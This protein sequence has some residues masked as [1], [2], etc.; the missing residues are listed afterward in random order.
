MAIKL[1]KKLFLA[2]S[3]YYGHNYINCIDDSSFYDRLYFHKNDIQ[4]ENSYKQNNNNTGSNVVNSD[5]NLINNNG[6]NVNLYNN[7]GSNVVNSDNNLINNSGYNVNLYNNAGSNIV[8]SVNNLI[9]NNEIKLSEEACK[10]NKILPNIEQKEKTKHNSFRKTDILDK[11]FRNY[12]LFL[13]QY[14]NK[15]LDDLHIKKKFFILDSYRSQI[16]AKIIKNFMNSVIKDVLI[17]SKKDYVEKNNKKLCE[18]IIKSNDINLKHIQ[19]IVKMRNIDFFEQVFRTFKGNLISGNKNVT[20]DGFLE[21]LKDAPEYRIIMES[22][23]NNYRNIINS[24]KVYI[25]KK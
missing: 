8:N 4:N 25:G 21:S 19:E 11:I 10:K 23:I 12:R 9:N 24:I 16:G 6:D 3:I 14:L 20:M 15:M 17:E 13:I 5:N 18:E 1:Y 2:N 22:Y 7:T